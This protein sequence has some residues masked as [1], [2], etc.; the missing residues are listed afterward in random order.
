[1]LRRIFRLQSLVGHLRYASLSKSLS[2]FSVDRPF[3]VDSRHLSK[4]MQEL[5]NIAVRVQL[6]PRSIA[7]VRLGYGKSEPWSVI[8]AARR[9][10]RLWL[11][12]K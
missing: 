11:E 2:A 6:Y 4:S 9:R 1:M 8:Q 7:T 10:K 3:V 5:K 12:K